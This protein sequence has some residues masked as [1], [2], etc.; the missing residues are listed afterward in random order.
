MAKELKRKRTDKTGGPPPTVGT[1]ELKCLSRISETLSSS[2]DLTYTLQEIFQILAD[3]MGMTRGTLTLLNARSGELA[4]R[5]SLTG[6]TP[7]EQKRGADTSSEKVSRGRVVESGETLRRAQDRGR[8][9][10]LEPGPA[11]AG[12]SEGRDISFLCV[13]ITVGRKRPRGP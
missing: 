10:V 1:L 5:D 11:R 2:L 6:L 3:F 13:P 8:T 7:E 12:P 9:A 4:H